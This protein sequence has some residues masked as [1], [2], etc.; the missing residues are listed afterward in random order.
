[1]YLICTRHF[2]KI[3]NKYLVWHQCLTIWKMTHNYLCSFLKGQVFHFLEV[4]KFFFLVTLLAASSSSSQCEF[5]SLRWMILKYFYLFIKMAWIV[6][7]T[8]NYLKMNLFACNFVHD[9]TYS[10]MPGFW[11]ATCHVIIGY[12]RL[13]I[14]CGTLNFFIYFLSHRWPQDITWS[15]SIHLTT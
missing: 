6:Y 1:M 9:W 2:V 7:I 8:K 3:I 13:H 10:W 14:P 4:A 5:I 12:E 11:R 15:T